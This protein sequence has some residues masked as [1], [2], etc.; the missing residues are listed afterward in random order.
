MKNSIIYAR[1]DQATV[2]TLLVIG[3]NRKSSKEYKV[4]PSENDTS[5]CQ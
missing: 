5:L 3:G 4:P 2:N 1:A